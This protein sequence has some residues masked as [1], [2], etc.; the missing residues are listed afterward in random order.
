MEEEVEEG[1]GRSREGLR[2]VTEGNAEI[3]ME[4]HWVKMARMRQ[5]VKDK[6]MKQGEDI[7][8]VKRMLDGMKGRCGSCMAMGMESS[9]ML[10]QCR[11]A[12]SLAARKLYKEMKEKIRK[13][14][15]MEGFSGC[16]FCFVPQRWC[17]SWENRWEGGFQRRNG[18]WRCQYQ[19][20]VLGGL[21]AG[22]LQGGEAAAEEMG[23]G[24]EVEGF[25]MKQ[26]REEMGYL[27]RRIEWGGLEASVLLREFWII[28]K[29]YVWR[30]E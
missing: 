16:S 13:T 19:E 30:W 15:V 17:D 26:D 8:E 4:S 2:R 18:V 25:D 5:A 10:Y 6:K 11:E 27:G 29:K 1:E 20:V 14:K 28:V 22:V 21:V 23:K 12:E 7:G 24:G 9:H 3:D